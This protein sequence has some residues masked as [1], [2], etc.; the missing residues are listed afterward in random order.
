[1]SYIIRHA[2]CQGVAFLYS[3]E[4]IAGA[5]IS[6]SKA[7]FPDGSKPGA[8]IMRCF[9]CKRPIKGASQLFPGGPALKTYD[10]SSPEDMERLYN[11]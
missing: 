7:I 6:R 3:E 10:M 11:G 4:P 2:V 8:G 5:T 1:M 9:H